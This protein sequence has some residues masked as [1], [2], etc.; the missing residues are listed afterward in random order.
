MLHVTE[1]F[2]KSLKTTQGTETGTI[3]KLG[4]GFPFAFHNNY[5]SILYHFRDKARY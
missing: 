4:Y 3:R 2:A 1:Y 5:V